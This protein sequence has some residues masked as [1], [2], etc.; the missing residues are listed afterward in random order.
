MSGLNG[1]A[2][3]LSTGINNVQAQIASVQKQL[4]TNSI[5]LNPGQLGQVTRLSSQVTNYQTAV[6]NITQAQDAINVAQT[7][8]SS[9]NT[10]MVQL[11]SLSNQASNAS[12]S[13]TDR[14]NLNSTFQSLL[15]QINSIAANTS[16]NGVNLIGSATGTGT[17]KGDDAV[18]QSG[19]S[20]A[21]TMTITATPS[22]TT[23][24]GINALAISTAAGA[25]AAVDALATALNTLSCNQ[26]SLAADYAGLTAKGATDSA[27]ATNLQSTIDSIQKP[28]QAELQMKLSQLNNQQ[29]IDYYLISQ[30]NT[31][32]SA[33]M[34]IFR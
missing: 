21:D 28:N 33:A 16:V 34:T 26:S 4:A 19:I 23:T 2:S 9:V 17:A 14:T 1:L 27:I 7:G 3:V 8:L 6:S 24:L 10:L 15:T 29:S 20:S 32:A 12:L 5:D 30:L 11:Q 13:A 31:A 25:S 22:D 18:I